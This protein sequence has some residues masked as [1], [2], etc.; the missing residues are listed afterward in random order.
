MT[1]AVRGTR[2][3]ESDCQ[4]PSGPSRHPSRRGPQRSGRGAE[5]VLSTLGTPT[6]L[7]PPRDEHDTDDGGLAVTG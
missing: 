1:L 6:W 4:A 3:T 5:G 2:G 7:S